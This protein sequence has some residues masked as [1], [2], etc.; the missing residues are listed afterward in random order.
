MSHWPCH[1][2][3]HCSLLRTARAT[4]AESFQKLA[5]RGLRQHR[6]TAASVHHSVAPV[7]CTA[8]DAVM[9]A[10]AS[11]VLGELLA[12]GPVGTMAFCEGQCCTGVC[13]YDSTSKT[14]FCCEPPRQPCSQMNLRTLPKARHLP[15][16]SRQ[17]RFE[18]AL[19]QI[20]QY[21]LKSML[22]GYIRRSCRSRRVLQRGMLFWGDRRVRHRQGR[23]RRGLCLLC[24]PLHKKAVI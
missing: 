22:G 20:S 19:T 15:P 18:H 7:A 17:A 24:D 21:P 14:Y 11:E 6:S 13:S 10:D 16:R 3:A 23:R 9:A 12:A 4:C 2:S 8:R 1:C 5:M